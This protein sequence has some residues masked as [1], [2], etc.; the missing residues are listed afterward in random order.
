MPLRRSLRLQEKRMEAYRRGE[1]TNWEQRVFNA[2]ESYNPEERTRS[3]IRIFQTL[4]EYP[5][6]L[7]SDP[8]YRAMA[9]AKFAEVDGLIQEESQDQWS[10]VA[11]V[12]RYYQTTLPSHPAYK[13]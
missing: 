2:I 12:F 5:C 4:L 1:H 8:S 9:Y 10:T 11:N 6:R 7:A 13:T 3:C